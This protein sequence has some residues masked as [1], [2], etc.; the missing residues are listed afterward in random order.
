MRYISMKDDIIFYPREKI[1]VHMQST[2]LKTLTFWGAEEGFS[3]LVFS[4]GVRGGDR[5]FIS[6]GSSWYNA[7]IEQGMHVIKLRSTDPGG[8]NRQWRRQGRNETKDLATHF[9][10]ITISYLALSVKAICSYTHRLSKKHNLW[11][12]SF[13]QQDFRNVK[14][15][16]FTYYVVMQILAYFISVHIHQEPAICKVIC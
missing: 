4:F 1:K 2:F 8:E 7:G 16:I 14:H 9:L 5:S 6:G 15:V 10:R 13:H 12:G 11:S 3:T